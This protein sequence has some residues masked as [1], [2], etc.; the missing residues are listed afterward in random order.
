[1]K[2][3]AILW[4]TAAALVARAAQRVETSISLDEFTGVLNQE[5]SL[6]DK[7]RCLVAL[8]QVALADGR[9]DLPCRWRLPVHD[10]DVALRHGAGFELGLQRLMPAE[11]LRIRGRHNASNALAALAL[12]TA[13]GGYH[14]WRT[15][16]RSNLG[17]PPATGALVASTAQRP[18]ARRESAAS[19]DQIAALRRFAV[20][21]GLAFQ[22]RDDLLDVEAP[23]SVSGKQQGKGAGSHGR[24]LLDGAGQL[25][26]RPRLGIQMRHGAGGAG[27]SAGGPRQRVARGRPP[28][29]RICT[30]PGA[31]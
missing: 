1:M 3:S 11:A 16:A 8:W 13:A 12:A 29:Y 25:T 2:R 21:A 22:I 5:C 26:A 18:A 7:R 27:R 6:A 15:S 28:P 23:T 14:V 4:L 17:L 10:G 30:P 19:K 9:L 24:V 31:V 20:L